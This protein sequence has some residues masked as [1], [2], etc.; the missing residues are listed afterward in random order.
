MKKTVNKKATDKQVPTKKAAT[1]KAKAEEA[2]TR[3]PSDKDI[4]AEVPNP[5]ASFENTNFL[6]GV[7]STLKKNYKKSILQTLN[8]NIISIALTTIEVVVVWAALVYA[9]TP[10]FNVPKANLLQAALLVILSKILMKGK[11][12]LELELHNHTDY[13]LSF[14]EKEQE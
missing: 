13:I 7:S 10:L 12:F 8:K 2:T 9:I 5:E 6:F 1:S 14:K 3:Q 11:S 4:M